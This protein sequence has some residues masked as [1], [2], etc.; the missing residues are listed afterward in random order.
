MSTTKEP[1]S[2]LAFAMARL[3]AHAADANRAK[4]TFASRL[5]SDPVYAVEWLQGNPRLWI[6]G[7]FANTIIDT[8]NAKGDD[9][10]PGEMEHRRLTVLRNMLTEIERRIECWTP[11]KSSSAFHNAVEDERLLA[12][13][14][15]RDT[16]RMAFSEEQ[17]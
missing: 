5:E 17:G 13:R 1:F 11:S 16:L 2:R 10:D 8:C 7:N 15:V 14:D 3:H 6:A 9:I 4:L 12:M